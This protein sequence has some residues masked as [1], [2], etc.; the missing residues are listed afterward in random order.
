MPVRSPPDDAQG[1]V[2]FFGLP[3]ARARGGG[4]DGE[5]RDAICF[6]LHSTEGMTA[7][8]F[9]A[10]AQVRLAS[11]RYGGFHPVHQA[12]VLRRVRAGDAGDLTLD[13]D[14]ELPAHI[15]QAVRA[16][17]ALLGVASRTEPL[18]PMVEALHDRHGELGLLHVD[19]RPRTDSAGFFRNCTQEHWASPQAVVQLGLRAPTER[20]DEDAFARIHGSLVWSVDDMAD[21]GPD[22]LAALARQR[23]TGRPLVAVLHLSALDPCHVPGAADPIPGGLTTR[24]LVRFVRNLVG[25]RIVGAWAVGAGSLPDETGRTA[26]VAAQLLFE[27]LA[28][29]ALART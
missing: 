26:G 24:E 29:V 28:L 3:A 18:C 10:P 11:A 21:H 25:L 15:R 1:F 22:N 13:R 2:T 4:L 19:A 14:G 6:G 9:E 17:S 16:G 8:E 5:P 7:S 23:L 20:A 27:T 12:D